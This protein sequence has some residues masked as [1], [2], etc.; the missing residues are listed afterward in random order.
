MLDVLSSHLDDPT[1]RGLA[2]AVSAAIRTGELTE[3]D[4]LPPIRTVAE[5][6]RLSPT[7]VSAAWSLLARAGTIRT[8]GRRG[9]TVARTR[10]GPTRYRR[11]LEQTRRFPLDLSSGV[12]DPDLLPDLSAALAGAG[13]SA[14][15]T[16][17][18]DEP[19]LPGLVE[20]LRADWPYPAE[21]ITVVDGAMDALQQ[22]VSLH[23]RLGDVVLVEHPCFPPLL[24]LLESVGARVVGLRMDA[25]GV[26]P[27][28]LE[29][30]LPSA[31]AVV[32]QPRAQNPTGVSTSPDRA[33]RLA[34][35]LAGGQALLVE[36]DSAGATSMAQPLSLGRWLPDRTLHVRSFSKSHG[37]DLRL[38]AVSGPVDLVGS[39]NDHRFLG[40][41][42]SSRLLQAVLL[43]LLTHDEPVRQVEAARQ[44]YAARRERVVSG[45][46]AAGLEVSAPDGINLWLPVR[47][48]VGALLRL[49]SEGI[50]AAAGG[51]FM[52]LP[53]DRPHLRVTVGLVADDHER[54]AGALAAAAEVGAWSG[55]R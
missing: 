37:P 27:E 38:A 16:S 55:P 41:G 52:V 48:E 8:D 19:T 46:A 53:D 39:L 25:Y 14:G 50:G 28:D 35:V 15:R 45:M 9:T 4:R 36:D 26:L 32:L 47:D 49:A 2:E 1:S 13:S 51:P 43:H 11:A 10:P 30:K 20:V 18:L 24:D 29:A 3:G 33:E 31:R 6:L 34:A 44:E 21:A 40:Q 12:P 22:I 23:L 54:V 5:H 42:W 17:Y 7:T